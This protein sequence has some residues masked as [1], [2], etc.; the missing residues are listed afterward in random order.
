[1]EVKERGGMLRLTVMV[2]DGKRGLKRSHAPKK[3]PVASLHLTWGSPA[4]FADN[5]GNVKKPCSQKSA[6]GGD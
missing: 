4:F 6:F 5:D 3:K 2:I 1:V